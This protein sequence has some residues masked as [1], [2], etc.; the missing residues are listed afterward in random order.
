[1]TETQRILRLLAQQSPPSDT[2]ILAGIVREFLSGEKRRE[3]LTGQRYYE[4]K[5]DVL[6]RTHWRIGENGMLVPDEGLPAAKIAHAFVRKLVDQKAQYLFGRPFTIR[7][8]NDV[9]AGLMAKV[10]DAQVR[11]Q[12]RSLCKE[13]VPLI[14]YRTHDLASIVPGTCA[15]G[16]NMPRHSTILG[17]SDDM[18]IFRGVNIYPGQIADVLGKYSEVGSEY[19]IQLTRDE[20]AVDHMKITIERAENMSSD[21]DRELAQRI[22]QDM[23]TSLFVRVD[24]VITDPSTLPRTFSKSKR[25]VDLR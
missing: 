21:S 22:A 18:I 12:M 1:M 16:L 5:T 13:A 25:I 19:Q 20:A 3:M 2:E 14:R 7:C 4:N 8:E 24:V 11:A 15:C 10:F 23:H 9:F 17:R 6:R